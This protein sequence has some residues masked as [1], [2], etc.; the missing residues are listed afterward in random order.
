MGRGLGLFAGRGL[1]LGTLYRG[2]LGG[3]LLA[4]ENLLASHFI[5]RI[6]DVRQA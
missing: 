5:K 1:T 4:R 6:R 3:G 2:G